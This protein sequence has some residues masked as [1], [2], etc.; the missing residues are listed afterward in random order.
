MKYC[1]AEMHKIVN[2]LIFSYLS[3]LID[4]DSTTDYR[5]I[6]EIIYYM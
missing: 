4:S 1:I 5:H 2:Y 6:F 3:E